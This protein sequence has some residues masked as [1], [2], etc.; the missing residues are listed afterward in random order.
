M[1][2]LRALYKA[3][4]ALVLLQYPNDAAHPE[5]LP[6]SSDPASRLKSWAPEAGLY[7]SEPA[8]EE[9]GEAVG[10]PTPDWSLA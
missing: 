8:G 7:T 10:F 5:M 2:S 9:E 6:Y 1:F 3:L 4:L